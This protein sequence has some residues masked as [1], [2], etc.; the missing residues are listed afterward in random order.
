MR[1]TLWNI[2]WEMLPYLET[3]LILSR[4]VPSWQSS[5]HITS[6]NFQK[7]KNKQTQTLFQTFDFILISF[8]M[9]GCHPTHLTYSTHLS[10]KIQL[11][12]YPL[13]LFPWLLKPFMLAY[14][15][16]SSVFSLHSMIIFIHIEIICLAS[17]SHTRLWV[18]WNSEPCLTHLCILMPTTRFNKYLLH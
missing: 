1:S 15:S 12:Y 16:S 7:T 11:R 3:K 2:P 6:N 5:T 17:E 13:K 10:F 4:K 18:S 9:A 8:Y 14:V